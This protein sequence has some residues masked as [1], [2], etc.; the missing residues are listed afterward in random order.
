M[1]VFAKRRFQHGALPEDSLRQRLPY[2][3]TEYRNRFLSL[4]Q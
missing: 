2:R 3:E 1:P 4:Y